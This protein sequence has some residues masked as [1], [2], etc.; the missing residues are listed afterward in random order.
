MS[1]AS[2]VSNTHSRLTRSVFPS[3]VTIR[4]RLAR[5]S[6]VIVGS[7]FHSISQMKPHRSACWAEA[8]AAVSTVVATAADRTSSRGDTATSYLLL[9]ELVERRPEAGGEL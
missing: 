8:R 5:L 4:C 2:T 9:T 1:S 6:I 3:G 7:T